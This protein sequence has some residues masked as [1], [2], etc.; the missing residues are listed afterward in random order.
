M[1]V[2]LLAFMVWPDCWPLLGVT[3]VLRTVEA[4]IVSVRVLGAK[5]PWALLPLQDALGFGFWLAGFFGKSISW[6]GQ[7]YLLNR[8]GTVQLAG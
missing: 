1:P 8:D 7:R 3:A 4:W 2:S 5:V 6:R